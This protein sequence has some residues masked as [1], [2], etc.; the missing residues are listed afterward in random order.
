MRQLLIYASWL[1]LCLISPA[2]AAACSCIPFEGGFLVSGEVALPSNAVGVPWWGD[3]EW[4]DGNFV[5]PS[6]EKFTV[7]E[8]KK[9]SW[10][11]VP[12]E[13][14]PIENE[15]TG[16]YQRPDK[17]TEVLFLVRPKAGFNSG[18]RY[19][20]TFAG[21]G[22]PVFRNGHSEIDKSMLQ[23]IVV[24]SS[25]RCLSKSGHASLETLAQGVGEI[26][27]STLGGSC[28]A[29][30]RGDRVRIRMNLPPDWTRWADVLFYTV[31]IHGIGVWR[32]DESLCSPTP[33]GRSWIGR[34]EELLFTSYVRAYGRELPNQVESGLASGT[35]LVDYIAWLP[36]TAEQVVGSA[37][38][39]L[40]CP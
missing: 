2:I 5:P 25:D 24:V 31:K 12:F 16:R 39:T 17:E 10:R 9:S 20:F 19:R 3:L 18:S 6:A 38:V 36:G 26:S 37:K 33:P 21:R 11:A 27:T 35:Y 34:G 14:I 32:P 1:I 23:T 30:V 4:K 40:S 8:W 13:L 29:T 15:M 22:R 7:E 28:A